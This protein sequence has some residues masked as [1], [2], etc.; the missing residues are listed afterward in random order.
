MQVSLETT[1]GLERRL[2]VGIPAAQVETEVETEVELKP[3]G[4]KV[5][6]TAIAV[7]I[8]ILGVLVL[9]I[10]FIVYI[11]FETKQWFKTKVIRMVRQTKESIFWNG[12]IRFYL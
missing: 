6:S 11:L 3:V 2:T 7:T 4:V 5:R 1:S 9:T 10:A 8:I 12:L